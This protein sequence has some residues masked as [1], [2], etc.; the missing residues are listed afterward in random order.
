MVEPLSP[1]ANKEMTTEERIK[2]NAERDFNL[3][4]ERNGGEPSLSALQTLHKA[5]EKIGMDFKAAE[6]LEQ[7]EEMFPGKGNLNNK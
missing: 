2:Y 1:F 5:Y 6:T 7:I 3:E 4:C